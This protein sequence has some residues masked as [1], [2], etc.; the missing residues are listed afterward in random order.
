MK[1]DAF[2]A[3]ARALDGAGVRYLVAGGVAVNAHGFLRFT[4]DIDIVLAL[5]AEN[6]T[7]AFEA[8]AALDYRPAVPV[9]ASGFGDAAMRRHWIEDKG[10]QV[11][12]FFSDCFPATSVD[13][14]VQEPFDFDTEYE[15]A[16]V[17]TL[18]PGVAPRFVALPTLIAMKEA[19]DRPGD[20][21]DI[22]YLRQILEEDDRDD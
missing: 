2:E 14:F 10:M 21:V 19:A 12:N 9:D 11:L 4:K 22:E 7:A 6:V 5:R 18:A 20:R 1:L 3:V 16:L 15:Q 8:L 17:A 13:V